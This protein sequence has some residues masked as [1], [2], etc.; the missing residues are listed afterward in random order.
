MERWSQRLEGCDLSEPIGAVVADAIE[1]EINTLS[2]QQLRCRYGGG[3][4]VMNAAASDV[5]RDMMVGS[6]EMFLRIPTHIRTYLLNN[7]RRSGWDRPPCWMFG[8]VPTIQTGIDDYKGEVL[9]FTAQSDDM[10]SWMWGDV[11]MANF[12]I[13]EENLAEQKWDQAWGFS[14]W[15]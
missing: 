7:R 10:L 3:T 2:R 13:S 5:Y 9:L 11:G 1:Q 14:E 4:S 6:R 8:W 12:M 15:T